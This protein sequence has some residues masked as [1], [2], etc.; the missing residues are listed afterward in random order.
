MNGL[1]N[2]L[3]GAFAALGGIL[4]R[5][6]DSRKVFTGLVSTYLA[7]LLWLLDRKFY[8]LGHTGYGSNAVVYAV[9][10][11]LARAVAEP[12]LLAMTQDTQGTRTKL[13]SASPLVQLLRVPTP[14]LMTM[15]EF[16]ELMVLY[17]GIS[18]RFNAFIE[19][20]NNG[21]PIGLWPLRPD[22]I[23]PIYSTLEETEAR[24]IKGWSYQVPGTARYV[25]I[26]REDVFTVNL[27]DPVGESGG[28]IEGLGPLQA[29]AMEVGADNEATRLVGSL[30][31][32][33]ATPS[34]AIMTKS[35][36]ANKETADLLKHAWMQQ[37][38]GTRRGE[39]AIL[40]AG[41]DIKQLSFNLSQLEFPQLR[42]IAEAR[43]AA[44]FGVPAALAGLKTG[45]DR[46]ADANLDG[47]RLYFTET[48]CSDYWRR[49]EDAFTMQVAVYWGENV[50]CTFDR[51]QV[52]AL[53][54]Q[55]RMEKQ[56]VADGFA[57][58]AVTVDEYR[59][60]VLNLDPLPNGQGQ[61]FMVP[62]GVIPSL[63]LA[64]MAA[65]PPPPPPVVGSGEGA[66]GA[67]AEA[68]S[69]DLLVTTNGKH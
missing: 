1:G 10:T 13:S 28:L 34:L 52:R 57:L 9:L 59:E 32:N 8:E 44:A 23:G 38:G 43:I 3:G 27:P 60:H 61:V 24:V 39:P 58:G 5:T 21:M 17:L 30:V 12:P 53:S 22:R 64:E 20:A 26:P 37:F 16:V 19:R 66:P 7:G 11:C 47:M 50:V 48:T 29:L 45:I 41:T 42:G 25:A 56:P 68:K 62:S 40:D 36:I 54:T 65:L 4:K 14:G 63:N 31:S 6:N 55:T 15:F 46:A 2:A 49:L 18:G 51:R 67:N 33:Y 35:P 69:A